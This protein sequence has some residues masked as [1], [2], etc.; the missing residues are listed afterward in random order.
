LRLQ[1]NSFGC[2]RNNARQAERLPYNNWKY[3]VD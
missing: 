1:G 2:Q 3:Y